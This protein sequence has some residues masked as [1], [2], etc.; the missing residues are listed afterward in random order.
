[1][2]SGF[3][4]LLVAHA[5]NR[6]I[7]RDGGMPW[8]L[9]ADLKRFKALTMGK[10]VLMGRK[11][12]ESIGKPLPGRENIVITRNRAWRADGVRVCHSLDAALEAAGTAE[13]MVIGGAGIYR[14]ALPL[15]RRIYLTLVYADIDGDTF[16]PEYDASEWIETAREDRA[17]DADN[18]HPLTFFTLERK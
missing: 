7:G 16:F 11:T 3:V 6:V 4:S 18:P 9:P 17:P 13:A 8:R 10:P 12:F 14:E 15:A 5:R 1:M 2:P